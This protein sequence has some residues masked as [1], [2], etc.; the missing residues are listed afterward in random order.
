MAYMATPWIRHWIQR[1]RKIANSKYYAGDN[2]DESRDHH[3]KC[4]RLYEHKHLYDTNQFET[5]QS[6]C[7]GF[8][9]LL[10]YAYE[11]TGQLPRGYKEALLIYHNNNQTIVDIEICSL[12]FKRC[13]EQLRQL[14]ITF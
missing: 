7:S 8:G 6:L 14:A 2:V 11:S 13:P 3:L 10:Q 12:D 9:R 1:R 5:E 4:L